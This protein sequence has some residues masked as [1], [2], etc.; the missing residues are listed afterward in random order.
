M[1]FENYNKMHSYYTKK[2]GIIAI[3]VFLV[4]V[5]LFYVA[6]IFLRTNG[7]RM[8]VP[9][10]VIVIIVVLALVLLRKEELRTLGIHQKGLWQSA[11]LGLALGAMFF[12]ATRFILDASVFERAY[13]GAEIM[14]IGMGNRFMDA[15][16]AS[17]MSWLPL[18][19]LFIII[20][21]V[22]QEV[23]FRSYIQTRLVGLL[24]SD[25]A[26]TAITAFLFALFFIPLHTILTGQNFTWVFMSSIPLPMFWLFALHCWLNFL[27]RTYNN[28]AAPIIFHIFF[29]FH[30]NI[31]LTHSYF[32]GL[33]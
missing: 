13:G 5:L 19:L 24:K 15:E 26:A 33:A 12:F 27:Y 17:L 25:L 22:S 29:S 30:S 23:L 4:S 31:A 14:R 7:M 21:V 2:D 1:F 32:M 20:T 11:L 18:A 9:A 16:E 3:A 6:G 8:F 28:I 10:S